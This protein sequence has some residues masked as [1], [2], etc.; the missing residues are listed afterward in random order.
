MTRK[1]YIALAEV[2]GEAFYRAS[3]A[4]GETGRTLVYDCAYRPLVARLELENPAFDCT[5]FSF[6]CAVAE[7]KCAS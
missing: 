2:M 6:A 1:D 5:R 4:N 7:G 3:Q